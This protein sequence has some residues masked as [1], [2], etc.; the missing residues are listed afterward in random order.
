MKI[1]NMS[2]KKFNELEPLK[3]PNNIF[4]TEA[5]M[6]ILEE[7]DKWVK[8]IHLLKKFYRDTGT[9][10]SNKL[11]TINEL[12]DRKEEIDIEEL[13]IP[14]KLVAV[15]GDIVGFSMPFIEN[16]NFQTVLDSNEFSIS[17]KIDYFKQIGEILEKM[18]KVR[19]YTE[20]SD[21]YLNDL[22]ENNFILNMNT[23]K[24]NA[25]DLD[26]CKISHNL[27]F[28]SRYLSFFTPM[29]NVSKYSKIDEPFS[30]G[31][32]FKVDQNTDYYC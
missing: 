23:G 15:H 27:T 8:S 10:F 9:V 30:I 31:A 26:S 17:Q 3:L 14:E 24:I 16:I 6:Y 4:N 13:V 28:G 18:R 7:K 19:K 12:I 20:L 25:V 32:Y 2:S 1:L 5:I 22:H 11:Y 21:F 29:S